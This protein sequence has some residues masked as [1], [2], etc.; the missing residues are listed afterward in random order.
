MH[1]TTRLHPFFECSFR[2]PHWKHFTSQFN[3]EPRSRFNGRKN[4]RRRPMQAEAKSAIQPHPV[5]TIP[6]RVRIGIA[7]VLYFGIE[8]LGLS[9][10]IL[11]SFEFSLERILKHALPFQPAFSPSRSFSLRLWFQPQPPSRPP[12]VSAPT[13]PLQQHTLPCLSILM[14]HTPSNHPTLLYAL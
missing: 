14:N 8:F 5:S 4:N 11:G 9:T 12:P 3:T 10:S 7:A 2:F 13:G 6:E 1:A